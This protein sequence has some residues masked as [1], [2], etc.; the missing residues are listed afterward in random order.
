VAV[1]ALTTSAVLSGCANQPTPSVAPTTTIRPTTIVI[2]D[3]EDGD[4]AGW[5]S[6]GAGPGGWFVYTGGST[7]PDPSVSDPGAAFAMP[8][9]PEGNHAAVTDM[10]GPGTRILFRDLRLDGRFKLHLNVFYRGNARFSSPATLAHDST[11]A[12]QQ[13]RV[14]LMSP[15][16]PIDSLA[17]ADVLLNVFHTSHGDP[18]SRMPADVVV[19]VSTLAGQTV[20]LRLAEADNQGPLRVGFDNVRFEPTG[21]AGDTIQIVDTPEA[22]TALE[23][24]LHR[25]SQADALAALV[26]RAEKRLAADEFSGAAL[27]ARD[28]DVLLE[29][30]WGL[31]D[32]EAGT[33]NST[34]TKFRIGSM[35]KMFTSVATLQ[36]VDAGK[37]ALDQPI[38]TYLPDYPDEA[39]RSKV[40]VRHL[41]SHTGGTGDIFGPQFEANRLELRDHADYVELYGSRGPLFEPGSRFEYSNYGFVLL[42]AVIEAVTGRPYYD[43]VRENVYGPA[44]MT[45]TDSLPESEPVPDRSSGYTRRSPAGRWLPNT[46][47]LPWRGTSAGGGYS[48][49]GDLMRFGDALRSGKLVS[50][51]SLAEATRPQSAESY[52]FGLEIRGEGSLGNYGHSGGAPG[53]NGDLRIYPELGYVV[54]S[55][56]NLDP[57]AAS[58]LVEYFTARMPDA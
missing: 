53:M 8:D 36:L 26:A 17:S 45:A 50:A 5:R 11:E 49:V 55:L 21:S 41:L 29:Q 15:T 42:G 39:I 44:G 48:T 34:A 22:S 32:R 40:T 58:D 18:T 46:D 31:A 25:L 27:V 3:F 33:P 24:V 51:A 37:L 35:N 6:V 23:L 57:P 52:G 9:P 30:A 13:F 7:A 16:A 56:S 43:V 10:N 12:N 28:G 14:D 1:A 2:D 20:R 38:G 54:V 19:D 47:T 4:L